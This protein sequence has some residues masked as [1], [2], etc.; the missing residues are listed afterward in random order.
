[1]PARVAGRVVVVLL[2]LTA[3]GAVLRFGVA[4]SLSRRDPVGAAQI[5]PSNAEIAVAAARALAGK[6]TLHQSR[7]VR[8]LVDVALARDVTDPT[9][10]ELKSL[11]SGADGDHRREARLFALSDAVSRRSLPTRLWLIQHAV[12]RGD[13][14]GAIKNFDVA[15]R[16]SS[17]A[18]SVLF[19][20]L[21]RASSDPSL[22]VPI[23]HLLDQPQDWGPAFLHYAITDGG[24]AA[25]IAGIVLHMRDR[26][27]ITD[28]DI[29][30][31]LVAEL[32]AEERFTQALAVQDTFHPLSAKSAL[33]RDPGFADPKS[34]YPFGWS[35]E[36]KGDIGA[37]R[38]QFAG[39]AVLS[40]QS[41][42]G[43]VGPVGTQLLMLSPGPYRL[44]VRTANAPTDPTALPLWTITCAGEEG[45]QIALLDQPALR[46][47]EAGADFTVTSGCPAQ[48]LVLILRESD[49]PA[50]QTGAISSV[51][52]ARR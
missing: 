28:N 3:V 41:L 33:V 45:A 20:V 18:P 31:A 42:P 29:D 46:D 22:T 7:E 16:T 19:P 8:R 27:W 15:L 12:D 9:A 35:F 10:I 38:S 30:D 25:G 50:G 26:R 39:R 24:A 13:L 52:I 17:D 47:S 43:G 6:N 48:W 1:M 23:A 14:K 51:S 21:A 5:A 40:Y 32:I 36:Q 49:L 44:T 4:T 2:A 34:R 37:E 11:Q